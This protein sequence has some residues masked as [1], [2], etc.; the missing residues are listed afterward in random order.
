MNFFMKWF[1]LGKRLDMTLHFYM[2][3]GLYKVVMVVTEAKWINFTF[4][5]Q[6]LDKPS[7]YTAHTLLFFLCGT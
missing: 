1:Q 3:S 7:K 6:W 5:V 2:W 4:A